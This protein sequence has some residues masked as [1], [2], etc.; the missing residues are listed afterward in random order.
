M[1]RLYDPDAFDAAAIN[2]VETDEM[3]P[4]AR[5]AGE[6]A[7]MFGAGEHGQFLSILG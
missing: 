7:G 1:L 2:R 6:F 5:R 4:A 3:I